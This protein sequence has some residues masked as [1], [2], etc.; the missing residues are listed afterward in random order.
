MVNLTTKE[1]VKR[2][3]DIKG[4]TLDELIDELIAEVTA[5]FEDFLG[6]RH[7]WSQERT[8]VYRLRAH[9]HTFSVDGAPVSS[10]TSLKYQS[11]DSDWASLDALDETN[12]RIDTTL[13]QV[14]LRGNTPFSPGFAQI[15]YTG[16]MVT[17]GTDDTES[18]A[19]F[20]AAHPSLAGAA[21]QQVVE[22]LRRRKMPT[23]STQLGKASSR[24]AVELHMLAIVKQRLSRYR[25]RRWC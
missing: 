16:G 7:I 3:M 25:R 1:R 13:G 15:V 22:I 24:Q 6:H 4:D 19:A 5:D 23:G 20:I 18:T 12:Y 17:P 21:D 14:Y 8:E 11:R 9:Q 10:V 2:R